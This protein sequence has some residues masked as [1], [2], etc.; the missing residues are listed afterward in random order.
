MSKKLPSCLQTQCEVYSPSMSVCGLDHVCVHLQM[1]L[2]SSANNSEPSSCIF[3]GSAEIIALAKG[4][5]HSA[6]IKPL[7]LGVSSVDNGSQEAAGK[8]R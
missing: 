8:G 1:S 7:R 2:S 4:T 5:T 6:G 3:S